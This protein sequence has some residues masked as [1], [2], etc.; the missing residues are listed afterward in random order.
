MPKPTLVH[1]GVNEGYFDAK[2]IKLPGFELRDCE[3]V[4]IG[5][6][7]IREWQGALLF[8]TQAQESSSYWVGDLVAYADTRV[9]WREKLDQAKVITGKK[10]GTLHNLGSIAR[11]VR[12][13]ERKL[14]PSI[15][16]SAIV[17]SLAVDEQRLWLTK[18]REEHLNRRDFRME[19][20]AGKRR[21]ML[22]GTAPLDGM[23]RVW[24]VDFPWLYENKQPS[25]TGA[26]TH[27]PGMEIS[28]GIDMGPA[29]QAHTLKDAVLFFWVTAPMLYEECHLGSPGPFAIIKAW[30]FT[31]KTQRIWDK[32]DHN[33]GSYL[34][35]RHEILIVATRGKNIT[36]DRPTPMQDSVVT[37]RVHDEHSAKPAIFRSDIEKLYDG[38]Y[39]E[40]FARE[41]VE[42]WT[43]WGNQ[44][45]VEAKS[46]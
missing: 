13:D 37:C 23:F 22:T 1:A 21:A 31:P 28:E 39:V 36:P 25:G 40:L 18:A 26:Q 46:A 15:E 35:V 42:G 6:P 34:S 10:E 45:M 5:T 16:H 8:A 3:A 12:L 9:E 4:P 20:R 24:Y 30:G 29:V 17:A 32:V 38:P 27:Y 14:S 43:C 44:I 7:T 19:V 41:R 2:P 33:V 11:R